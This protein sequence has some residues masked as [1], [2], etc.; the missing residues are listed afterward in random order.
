[1]RNNLDKFKKRCSALPQESR[2]IV[3]A[4]FLICLR[5]SRDF[6]RIS[7]SVLLL[8]IRLYTET[9]GSFLSLTDI[10]LDRTK[11]PRRNW[12]LGIESLAWKGG[13]S[14][15]IP[16]SRRRSRPGR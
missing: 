12:G 15:R 2:K 9:P 13:G 5:F 3:F 1:M 8:E 7:K 16:V 10:P 4:S 6:I 14:G 11:H